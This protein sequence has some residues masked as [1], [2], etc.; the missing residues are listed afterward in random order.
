MPRY[1]NIVIVSSGVS[2]MRILYQYVRVLGLQLNSTADVYK[3]FSMSRNH[4]ST[5]ETFGDA[6]IAPCVPYPEIDLI[7]FDMCANSTDSNRMLV[8]EMY[9]FGLRANELLLFPQLD[10]CLQLRQHTRRSRSIHIAQTT[11]HPSL[12]TSTERLSSPE[13]LLPF[14]RIL[15]AISHVLGPALHAVPQSLERVPD[16]FARAARHARDRLADASA[17]RADDAA[18]RLGDSADPVTQGGGDEAD[19]VVGVGGV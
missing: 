9:N 14:A 8:L 6:S 5:S 7:F 4:E 12:S 2:G 17:C 19:R 16:R 13:P 3:V 15:N 1:V 11:L 10:A 18:G